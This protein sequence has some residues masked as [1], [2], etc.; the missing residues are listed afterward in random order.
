MNNLALAL[1]GSFQASLGGTSLT[2]FRTR[3]VQALLAYLATEPQPHG[4]DY[5]LNLLWPG[6]PEKS[7][8]SNLRQILYYLRQAIPELDGH[9]RT[10][11]SV[12]IANRQDIQLNQQADIT[13]DVQ[14][15]E[16]LLDDAQAHQHLDI[17]LCHDCRQKLEKAITLYRGNFLADFYL[18]DS[19]E[20]EEWAQSRREYFRRRMLDALSILTTITTRSQE[21]AAAQAF[22]E[23]QLEIDNLREGAYRQLMAILAL[24]GRREQALAVYE[25]CRRVLIEELGM[26]PTGRTTEYY[27]KILAGKLEFDRF[28][29]GGV[30]GYELKEKIGE[31]AYGAIHRAVQPSVKREVAV[32]V[33]RRRYADDP[34]FIRRFD[35]EAQIVA[36]LEHPYIVPLY[37]YWRDP[38][39]AYL[40]MRYMRGGSLLG[41]LKSG[42]WKVERT[43]EML[44][45][46][47]GA[48]TIAH[49]L[50]VVHRDIKP[51][52]ILLD[53]AGNAYLA[54]FGIA[55]DLTREQQTAEGSVVGTLDYASPEQITGGE[56]TAQTDM[57]SLGAVIYETLTGEKPFSDASVAQLLHSHLHEPIPLVAATRPD[58]SPEIDTVLQKA[59]AKL[60]AERYN[61]V[62]EMAAAFR[63]VVRGKQ[64]DTSVTMV[65]SLPALAEVYNPYK[66]LYAFQESDADD[67]YGREALVQ[68]LVGRLQDG[69]EALDGRFLAVVGPSGSGKSSV[70]KAG[71]IP[72]LRN[73]ALPNSDKWFITEMVPGNSPLE[74]LELAL[75]RV[76]VDAPPNLVEPMKRDTGGILRTIRRILPDERAPQQGG[77]Q[78]VLVIDQFEE[79]FTLVTDEEQRNFFLES[80]LHA[81]EA[82]RSP[83]RVVV[84]LRA[85]F[86]D[87]PLQH[88]Q[89]GQLLKQHTEIVLPLNRTELTWAIREPAQRLGIRLEEGLPAAIVGD[90]AD[91]PGALP[92]LQYALTELF[93]QRDGRQ[94]SQQAYQQLGGVLGALGRRAEA[95]FA[96]L[97]GTSQQM[98]QQ[99][100]L[101]LITLGEGAEDT[102]RRVLQSELEALAGESEPN[103]QALTA[104]LE[105]FGE[106][107]FLTF[108]RDPLTRAPT[109]EVA[110]EALIREWA[111]L[112]MWLTESRDDVRLQRLLAQTAAEW[113][114]AERAEGFLLRDARLD[115]FAGWAE[116]T[117]VALTA[118]EQAFIEA[119]LAARNARLAEEE[120]RR[121]RELETVQK[122]AET[123]KARA[124][125]E[126]QK[127]QEQARRAEEQAT[128]AQ[129]LRQRA[130]YLG[131]AAVVAVL[132][133]IAAGVFGQR[134]LTN[135]A[136]AE[137]SAAT[138]VA[139]GVR[140]DQERDV[141]VAAQATSEAEAFARATAEAESNEQRDLAQAE[142]GVR[143]TAEAVA[144]DQR[145]VAQA[146]T[147][148]AVSRE[149]SQAAANVLD[150]DPELS[151]LLAMEAINTT[152]TVQA[153]EALRNA[154]QQSRARLTIQIE[155]RVQYASYTPDGSKILVETRNSIELWDA[156][157]GEPISSAPISGIPY[158]RQFNETGDEVWVVLRKEGNAGVELFA[159]D[160]ASSEVRQL[161]FFDVDLPTF[162][163]GVLSPDGTLL[164]IGNA[165]NEAEL[166]DTETGERLF[167][168]NS[169][170]SVA[171][172]YDFNVDGSQLVVS[173]AEGEVE[174]FDIPASLEAG[175]P[176]SVTAFTAVEEEL[177]FQARFSLSG[178]EVFLAFRAEQPLEIWDVSVPNDPQLVRIIDTGVDRADES[179]QDES[180]I[181]Q[182]YGGG[183][184]ST[185]TIWEAET[186]E[187]LFTLDGHKGTVGSAV[188][189]P[190]EKTI[191]TSSGDGTVRVWDASLWIGGEVQTGYFFGV[192][193]DL[194]IS[195]N[196]QV[197]ALSGSLRSSLSS[198]VILDRQTFEPIYN[199]ELGEGEVNGS[200]F[201]PDGSRLATVGS[202]NV[203]RIWDMN[204]GEPLLSWVGH[205]AGPPVGGSTYGVTKVSYSPDG[206]RLVTAGSDRTAK[207]WDAETGEQLLVLE[208]HAVGLS[209]L[210]YSPDGKMIATGTDNFEN[211]VRVW[212]AETG[213]EIYAL[214]A[215]N[216]V[217]G[218]AFSPDMQLLAATGTSGFIHL[219]D[220]TTG[221]QLYSFPSLGATAGMVLFTRD[222]QQLITIGVGG[223]H[224]WDVATGAQ[225][226][227]ITSNVNF[228]AALTADGRYLYASDAATGV[229]QVFTIDVEDTIAVASERLTRPLTQEECQVYLHVDV[230][231]QE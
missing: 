223:T 198:A 43:A 176:Q 145:D 29:A 28:A 14:Q 152:Y 15:F 216:R 58:V 105:R 168:L 220:L 38:Q 120:A 66:G 85:D 117:T 138:A 123:E 154:L 116:T 86:Y 101:R 46:I 190:D 76:A 181:I 83:L 114:A 47:A 98:A 44:E 207:V 231:P 121:Q 217:Y 122:L 149:L 160:M 51:G 107:R 170:D 192:G 61:S 186:G 5:L 72:A 219:W 191:L 184:N 12:I 50:G 27:E 104:V 136:A 113:L 59:T 95:V 89:W 131:V 125:A 80:L 209:G 68:Q 118:D 146:Q 23:K 196:E 144:L 62:L 96:S 227:M 71:L 129:S 185:V 16:I 20:F 25:T 22:A 41:E 54:D 40:V 204:N 151:M 213:E 195:P 3:K 199:L 1:F 143:A 6:L 94:I 78:L 137:S 87:R 33:I 102:R 187:P 19:N 224:L 8:R 178:E 140:A 200:S 63:H 221:T 55:K 222:G 49:R 111:Q 215:D 135:A 188:F 128:A 205:E 45:Q 64:I 52:N 148:L 30:R 110:H 109:V 73:G 91:Q 214:Q 201:H 182:N 212:D 218:I 93:E 133:A 48:L 4:R 161:Q 156:M 42:P 134:S 230:C 127:A 11:L 179:N 81:L 36:R 18:D 228:A 21:Y 165:S 169:Y 67:F 208:G 203:I 9:G 158:W 69:Y 197:I 82:P 32:K 171:W 163:E 39:G 194:Q 65:E 226:K 177:I 108:D 60:P 35:T 84:T 17:Y 124:E 115:Q 155:E 34:E 77:S 193:R 183:L 70:V 100:F 57:Y 79:L 92:L 112:R 211:M 173:A 10:D 162:M 142:A 132:L 150:A 88:P 164:A 24:N 159:W 166:W 172:D 202:D 26:E 56:I 13:V 130:V 2:D 141:A 31:G 189:S 225:I 103:Q 7:A 53:E 139:E 119:S 126:H 180:W 153:E 175:S 74:E 97:D 210:Q 147:D 167:V 174:I 229:I 157:T 90:V 106:A 37:D 206:T 75:W 99:V